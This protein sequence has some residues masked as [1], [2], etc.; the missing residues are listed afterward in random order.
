[1][2][3][4]LVGLSHKTAPVEVRERLHF[5]DSSL[6]KALQRLN[7]QAA[8]AESLIL[9]TCNRMEV[10]AH[11]ADAQRGVVL[12]RQFISDFHCQP[13]KSIG[14]Y[15]Y[16]L[17]DSEV[18]R[19][20][21]RVASSLDSMVLGEPQILGQFKTAFSLARNI[22]AVGDALSP[23]IHRAFYVAKRVRSE[24]AISSAAVSVSYAAVE[25][26]KKIF[27]HLRG[28]TVLLLGA[29]KMS[30]LAA[31]HLI[32]QGITRL[33]VW[34][35]T[36]QRAVSMAGVLQGEA[37][38]TEELF[39]HVERADILICSTG[40]PGVILTKSDGQRL[41]QLRK[42]RPVFIIDIAVPRDVDP[43]LNRLDNIFLY[44]I[45]DLQHVVDANLK[46][47]R[48]EAQ[49]AETIIQEEVQSYIKQTR[50]LDVAPD[51]VSLREHWD[52]IR[53]EELAR[54]RKK[55]GTL[56]DQQEAALDQLT[57]GLL[58]K[59]L[60]GPISEMKSLGQDP[61]AEPKITAIKRMLGLKH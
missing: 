51:I 5:P 31:R 10:L 25:L 40:S 32:S 47:R 49:F 14:P 57:R 52:A 22:G 54:N 39:R 38:P 8:I 16:D 12:V 53:R 46:H 21:F 6:Q 36:Y 28:R 3:L 44:N 33:L 59:I 56:N 20:V 37:I 1:M 30:E 18:V 11:S 55:L 15:L 27:D 48:K 2:S 29:G 35:R 24:T 13:E 61:S 58:N 41:I 45:D 7:S 26:A 19:H 43:E 17:T 34:N 42:N 60:H 23:L 4:L 9:S 50:G